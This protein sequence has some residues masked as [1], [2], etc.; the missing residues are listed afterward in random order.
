MPAGYQEQVTARE[1]VPDID[2]LEQLAR[3]DRSGDVAVSLARARRGHQAGAQDAIALSDVLPVLEN[4]GL[5]VIQEQPY[6]V[7]TRASASGCTTSA[8]S[9][10][11]RW[12]STSIR[13]AAPS[14]RPPRVWHGE[15]ESDGFNQLVLHGLDWRQITVLRAYCKY[16]LQ[17]GIPFS[18]AYMEQTLARNPALA[19][20]AAQ[21]F[22]AKFDPDLTGDRQARLAELAARAGLDAVANLDEDRILRRYMRLVR[23][24]AHQLL[25]ARTGRRAVQAVPVA[26]DRSGGAGDAAAAAGVRDF[27]LCPAHRRRAPARRQ[28]GARRHPVVGPARTSAPRCSA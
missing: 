19:R 1:A 9:R 6:E 24:A 16:L 8:C 18:Q 13:C 15:V 21:L 23:D 11:R 4:M 22:E 20:Q 28:G 3:R 5:R 27:R 10:S 26:Q 2:R 12:S 17:V 25:P 7:L 14:R